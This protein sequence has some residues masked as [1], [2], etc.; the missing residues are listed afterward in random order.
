MICPHV[1]D[2]CDATL[3]EGTAVFGG[4][5]I[6]SIEP[7]WYEVIWVVLGY[8]YDRWVVLCYQLGIRWFD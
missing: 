7:E 1:K 3:D 4:K 5:I 2:Y 6:V 8:F